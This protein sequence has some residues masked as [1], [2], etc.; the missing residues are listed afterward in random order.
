MKPM[1]EKRESLGNR[2]KGR[3]ALAAS[4]MMIRNA[5]AGTKQSFLP[6]IYEPQFSLEL[7]KEQNK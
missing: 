2:I 7:L 6:F 3:V 1:N 4:E 5:E